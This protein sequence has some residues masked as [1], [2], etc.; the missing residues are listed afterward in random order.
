MHTITTGSKQPS[1]YSQSILPFIIVGL[2]SLFYL[3]DYFIQVSPSVMTEQLMQSFSIGAA[4]LGMLGACFYAAYTIMQIPAGLLL[5]RFGARILLTFSVFI[6]ACGVTLFGATHSFVVAE[7]SRFLI[8]LG[9]AFAFI[10][11]LFL[12]SR[13]FTHKHFAMIAGIIQLAGCMGSIF[14]EAPLAMTINHFGWRQTM[15]TTG[16]ITFILTVIFW[17]F[18]RNGKEQGEHDTHMTVGNEKQ[19][20]KYILQ[21]PQ[22]WWIAV[23]GLVSW[24]PVA[25]IGALWGVS[26]LMNVYGLNNAQA[27][28]LCSLFWFGL[29][30]GSPI[31]GWFSNHI[32]S[33][34]KPFIFCFSVAVLA[35]ILMIAAPHLPMWLTGVALL[36][37]GM[38]SSVQSLSFGLIKDIVNPSAFGT[39]A[40]FNNMAAIIGGAI[41]LPLVGILIEYQWNGLSAHGIP[42]YTAQNYQNALLLVPISAIIGL[43][44]TWFKIKETHCQP[45]YD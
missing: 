8:G 31:V 24:V 14:G 26:Y 35:S 7:F 19:R 29:G 5:D 38:S 39:A 40:G 18:I 32:Q 2:A 13:W 22:V 17:V 6:S 11:A 12:V 44:V 36:C 16:L 37:L 28:K 45:S 43:L 33:R 10:C 23:C 27:G 1:F 20:L 3:Y 41:S 4:R 42:V 15:V 25:T 21:K 30:L 9:S 34:L